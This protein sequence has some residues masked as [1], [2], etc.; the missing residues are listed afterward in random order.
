[1]LKWK[2]VVLFN[3]SNFPIKE[4][5]E[6]MFQG[7]TLSEAEYPSETTAAGMERGGR[8]AVAEFLPRPPRASSSWC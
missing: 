3:C 7:V 5:K 1:M 4:K 2:V 8:L 6:P